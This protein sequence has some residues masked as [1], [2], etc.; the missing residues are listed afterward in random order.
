MS[1]AKRKPPAMKQVQ[2]EQPNR[3]AIAVFSAVFGVV[4]VAMIVLLIV[5]S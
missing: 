4:A 5:Y 1:A 2:K 3:K